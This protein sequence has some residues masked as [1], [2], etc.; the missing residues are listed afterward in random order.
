MFLRKQA[1]YEKLPPALARLE[2]KVNRARY[3]SLQWKFLHFSNPS[4]PDP[5]GCG[6]YCNRSEKLLEPVLSKVTPVPES[7]LH[8]TVCNFKTKCVTNRCKCRKN[9]LNCSEM[10]DCENSEN[11]E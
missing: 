3:I 6:W 10:Y 7:I 1:D 8:L 2:E 9:G 5:S 11:D 4:P